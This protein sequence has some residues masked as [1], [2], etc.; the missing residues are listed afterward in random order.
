M[1]KL[2]GDQKAEYATSLAALALYDG[3]VS[4][5]CAPQSVSLWCCG[6]RCRPSSSAFATSETHPPPLARSSY[7][8]R[9]KSFLG[10]CVRLRRTDKNNT[11]TH[12]HT[13]TITGRHLLR[14]DQHPPRGHGQHRGPS[15]PPHHIR[16]LPHRRAHLEDDCRARVRRRWWRRWRRRRRRRSRGR[17][18]EGGGRGGGRGGPPRGRQ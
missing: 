10:H 18:E 4:L 11:H 12:T 17:G 7:D 1:D 13:H 9:G 16:Q 8:P 5:S 3:G 6:D 2:T 15:L 14:S